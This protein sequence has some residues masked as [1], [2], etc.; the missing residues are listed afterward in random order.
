MFNK[1]DDRVKLDMQAPAKPAKQSPSTPS[2]AGEASVLGAGIK[3]LGNLECDGDIVIAGRVEGDIASCG[4]TVEEGATIKGS[5]TVETATILGS[6][7]GQVR[8]RSV[9]IGNSGRMM[10]EVEY[11]S[12]SINEGAEIDGQ[13][14][15]AKPSSTR[16]SPAA[17]VAISRKSQRQKVA[18]GNQCRSHQQ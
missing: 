10:G 7:E 16:R 2:A 14:H 12:L 8:A 18:P 17:Q 9:H 3:M 5:I 11:E 13:V 15:K 6:V 1:K 4:L